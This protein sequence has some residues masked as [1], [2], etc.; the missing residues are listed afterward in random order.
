M[1]NLVNMT[2]RR[3]KRLALSLIALTPLAAAGVVNS[4]NAVHS[5]HVVLKDDSVT[6]IPNPPQEV[7]EGQPISIVANFTPESYVAGYQWAKI[8][9]GVKT[10]LPETTKNLIYYPLP[11]E[12][13]FDIELTYF[14]TDGTS[15][16][17]V[18]KIIIV[19]AP[20][21]EPE[22]EPVPPV[23]P[24]AGSIIS[25]FISG[26]K[27]SYN[28]GEM[29]KLKADVTFSGIT[30]SMISY[31]W[32]IYETKEV[33]GHDQYLNIEAKKEYNG[34]KIQVVA[35]Y[36]GKDVEDSTI[37][38]QIKTLPPP[39]PPTPPKPVEPTP[40]SKPHV[41]PSEPSKPSDVVNHSQ[42]F[43]STPLFWVLIVIGI[44]WIIILIISIIMNINKHKK[45]K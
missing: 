33:I 14:F 8:V 21:P 2:K 28:E 32:R 6:I 18:Q 11:D 41:P 43:T 29:I 7:V 16:S 10:I 17:G 37:P 39:V 20:P 45:Q 22:P 13:E 5:N 36:G 44:I 30:S 23:T 31:E 38:L 4:V 3:M 34:K 25:V 40:P 15:A 12:K 27:P 26:L 1:Y 24:P 42:S 19:P 9:N 35:S